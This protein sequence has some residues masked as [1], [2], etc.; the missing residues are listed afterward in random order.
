MPK[1]FNPLSEHVLSV[2]D[3]E[4]EIITGREIFEQ[5]SYT[6]LNRTPIMKLM[7]FI[8]AGIVIEGSPPPFDVVE[9]AERLL[10]DGSF[11][12]F[13]TSQFATEDNGDFIEDVCHVEPGLIYQMLRDKGDER[14]RLLKDTRR[15]YKLEG[16]TWE[17]WD[18]EN[19]NNTG[20]T[21]VADVAECPAEFI[22]PY[23]NGCGLLYPVQ[24]LYHRLEE[25]QCT[26][27]GQSTSDALRTIISG[28]VGNLDSVEAA[29]MSGRKVLNIPGNVTVTR[30]RSTEA[31]SQL[32]EESHDLERKYDEG[33]NDYLAAEDTVES[34]VAR[35]LKMSPMLQFVKNQRARLVDIFD[36]FS[37]VLNFD[38]VQVQTVDERTAEYNLLKLMRDDGVIDDTE[39]KARSLDLTS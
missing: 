24:N 23:E 9:T 36:P 27:R 4:Y 3:H 34:G 2:E 19:R 39:F 37:V 8:T 26:I 7:S 16:A 18:E 38:K 10:V 25:L 30:L 15:V 21:K 6:G 29:F 28:F 14:G 11:A 12:V 32:L 13:I 1:Q 20:W 22:L 17:I 5:M 31:V 33:V 35:R